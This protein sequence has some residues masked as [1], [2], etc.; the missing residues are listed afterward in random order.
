MSLMWVPGREEKGEGK[1]KGHMEKKQWKSGDLKLR[2]TVRKQNNLPSPASQTGTPLPPAPSSSDPHS[3]WPVIGQRSTESPECARFLVGRP[4]CWWDILAGA[5]SLRLTPSI[6]LPSISWLFIV[7][8][9]SQDGCHR[10][11]D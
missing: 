1:Q 8:S 7:V 6:L 4:C 3:S 10:N 11:P 2:E 9:W 5:P